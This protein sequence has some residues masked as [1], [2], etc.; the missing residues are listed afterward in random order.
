MASLVLGASLGMVDVGK[1]PTVDLFDVGHEVT[2]GLSGAHGRGAYQ[3]DD[4]RE[5]VRHLT[6]YQFPPTSPRLPLLLPDL[7]SVSPL[8][9]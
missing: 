5:L 3:G 4:R 8:P 6:S 1:I 2:G 7:I 9:S